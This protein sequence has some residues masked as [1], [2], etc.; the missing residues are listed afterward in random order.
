MSYKPAGHPSVAPYL[1]VRS[2]QALVDFLAA[3]ADGEE[4]LRHERDDGSIM[5]AEVRIDDAI[6]MLGGAANG[7]AGTPAH[8]HVYV[9]DV[10]DTYARALSAGGESV[11]E[12]KQ[13]NDP[14][15]R[16]G[17][18]GPAGNTWW[19]STHVG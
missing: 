6:V 2:P 10:D 17:V 13:Q 18:K 9:P 19:F 4:V 12:P 8:V 11:Q 1:I 7:W 15:R 14:D 5:H 16:C 3:A